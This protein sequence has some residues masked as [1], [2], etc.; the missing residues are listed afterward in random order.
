VSARRPAR[1][2]LLLIVPATFLAAALALAAGVPWLFPLIC[3]APACV[4]LWRCLARGSRAA[5]FGGLLLWAAALAIC[6]TAAGFF[7]EER[8]ARAILHG[9]AYAEEMRA[10][11]ATGVGRESDPARF[12]PQ[13]LLH[14]AIF[15]ALAL[16]TAGAG[17]LVMGS[18]LLGYMSFYVGSL[19]R[20]AAGCAPLATALLAW[21]PWSLVRIVS[22]IALGVVLSEPML[23]RWRGSGPT[24]A[25]RGLWI[26]AGLAGIVADMLLKAA[27]APAWREMLAACAG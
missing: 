20:G 21:N 14:L 2:G 8:A 4:H 7:Q 5:A 24:S 25:G 9:T 23:A 19:A 17:A 18:A 10:W 1:G 12:V 11:I 22:F 6:G 3:A 27:L 15:A 13:H 16:I 26:A